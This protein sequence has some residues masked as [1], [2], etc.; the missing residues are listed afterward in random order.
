MVKNHRHFLPNDAENIPQIE[1]IT[2]GGLDIGNF[3][4]NT[5]LYGFLS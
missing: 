2:K 3:K 5:C 1:R 4:N